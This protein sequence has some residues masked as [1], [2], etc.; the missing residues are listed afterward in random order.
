MVRRQSTLAIALVVVALTT[1]LLQLVV[2][3][4]VLLP[5]DTRWA[6]LL[7]P[8][9]VT[10]V[11]LWSLIHE[12]IHGILLRDRAWNDRLGRVL[13]VGYG[14]PFTLLKAGHLLHHRY[15]RTRRERTEVYDPARSTWL[16]A[17]RGYYPRLLG[18]LYFLEL[19]SVLLA[20]LP[21]RGWAALV[22]RTDSLDSVTGLLFERVARRDNLRRFRVE[23]IAIVV[24]YTG[25]SIAYGGH[26]W[27]LWSA[28]GAR[29]LIVSLADNAYH[30][31]TRLER[32][33]DA[34]NLALPRAL[35]LFVLAFN[36]HNV[37]HRHPGLRWHELRA[38]YVADRDRTHLGWFTAVARQ[39]RGP[40][41][42]SAEA[43]RADTVPG[44]TAQTSGAPSTSP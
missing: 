23:A 16:A 25:S 21:R 22:R 39:L 41:P 24:T 26:A 35:E 37:H 1:L 4:L 17:A 12:G 36:L 5:R 2:L 29:A 14:G 42:L 40:V 28:V 38:A 11:P 32:P 20:L 33:L 10:T 6:W 31:G 19:L 15:S 3:P 9:A 27:M 43:I 7:A 34:M 13:A 8:I 44:W 18:G 30:Y